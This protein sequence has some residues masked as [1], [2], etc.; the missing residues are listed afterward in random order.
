MHGE[1]NVGNTKIKVLCIYVYTDYSSQ[2]AQFISFRKTISEYCIMA[3]CY[4][5]HMERV[6]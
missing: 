3:V 6:G 5:T 1:H 2:N 4:E